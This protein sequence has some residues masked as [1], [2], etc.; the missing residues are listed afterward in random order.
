M[1]KL[2]NTEML[3]FLN[4]RAV[5]KYVFDNKYSF[6]CTKINKSCDMD[7]CPILKNCECIEQFVS[8]I[9]NQ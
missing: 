6:D 9:S 2:N 1:E 5:C 4:K 3:L 7:D 8:K